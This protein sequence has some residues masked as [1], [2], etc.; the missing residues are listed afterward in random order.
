MP[1]KKSNY[2]FYLV[3]Y[4]LLNALLIYGTSYTWFWVVFLSI[5]FAVLFYHG[6]IYFYKVQAK[7]RA[8]IFKL[9]AEKYK[10]V[11]TY[12][13][14]KIEVLIENYR[15]RFEF[16]C[17]NSSNFRIHNFL[18][19]Y[20]QISSL[21]IP[22]KDLC[23]IHFHHSLKDKEDYFA[24]SSQNKLEQFTKKFDKTLRKK[25]LGNDR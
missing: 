3:P 13:A 5:L 12:D 24:G 14:D 11:Q 9:L 7:R 19:I 6:E 10:N 17:M 8:K 20:I 21:E 25:N 22:L 23:K 18:S 2:W 4:L 16:R 1:T 15:V